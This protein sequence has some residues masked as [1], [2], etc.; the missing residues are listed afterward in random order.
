MKP[1]FGHCS[2]E[3]DVPDWLKAE[4]NE[5][6]I[7]ANQKESKRKERT[8][9]SRD[10]NRNERSKVSPDVAKEAPTPTTVTPPK[11]DMKKIGRPP[12]SKS[13]QKTSVRKESVATSSQKYPLP[14]DKLKAYHLNFE[15]DEEGMRR[16]NELVAKAK[17]TALNYEIQRLRAELDKQDSSVKPKNNK[18]I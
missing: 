6:V 17:E 3:G 4:L 13:N 2:Y 8:S 9:S 12:Y 14:K 11:V 15:A 7:S 1:Y 10:E 5:A 16:R 18:L